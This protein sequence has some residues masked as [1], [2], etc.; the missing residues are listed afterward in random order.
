MISAVNI[1]ISVRPAVV[2]N[3]SGQVVNISNTITISCEIN[4][5]P[6]PTIT[7]LKDNQIVD[8]SKYTITSIGMSELS[9]LTLVNA[10]LSDDGNYRCKG[11][12]TAGTIY[13]SEAALVIHCKFNITW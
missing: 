10:T 13:T 6:N 4:G 8:S 12:N 7:W 11:E 3:P 9:N 1:T 5:I 2:R